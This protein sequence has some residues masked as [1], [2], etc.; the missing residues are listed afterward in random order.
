MSIGTRWRPFESLPAPNSIGDGVIT[1]GVDPDGWA[2]SAIALLVE[3]KACARLDIQLV[4]FPGTPG[5]AGITHPAS[6]VR[7][8]PNFGPP[9]TVV[10]RRSPRALQFKPAGPSPRIDLVFSRTWQP[11]VLGVGQDERSL[12]A[13]VRAACA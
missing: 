3:G 4:P 6:R 11:S 1:I 2:G 8:T 13:S 7:I 12:S 10:L 9:S 5:G